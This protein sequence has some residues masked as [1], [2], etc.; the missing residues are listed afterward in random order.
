MRGCERFYKSTTLEATHLQENG[1][2]T[3]GTIRADLG[4]GP[5]WETASGL[6]YWVDINSGLLHSYDEASGAFNTIPTGGQKVGAAVSRQGGGFVL[7]LQDGF[8]FLDTQTGELEFIADPEAHLPGN[9]FNDGKVDPAGR[10]WAGTMADEAGGGALYCLDTDLSVRRMVDDV[11]CSNGLAW[12]A[13]NKT[14]YYIDSPTKQVVA[15][16]YDLASGD[17][18]NRRVIIQIAEGV[19]D[20]MAIDADGMLWIAQWGGYQ[21]SRWNPHTGTKIGNIELPVSQVTSCA[22]AGPGLSTLYITSA[23]TGLSEE[24]LAEEPLAGAL[25]TFQPG[26]KGTAAHLFGG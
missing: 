17:I 15:Y 23:R 20:G 22:F 11:T 16:D 4:E 26:V 21:V 14:M 24:Q 3:I 18:A 13:D 6:L 1:L 10:F 19:P 9:R 5:V 25:F 2:N 7:A 12:S 8:H